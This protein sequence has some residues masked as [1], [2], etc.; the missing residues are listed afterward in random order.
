[1]LVTPGSAV[2]DLAAVADAN[3]IVHLAYTQTTD[4]DSK[5]VYLQ[6]SCAPRLTGTVNTY[7]RLADGVVAGSLATVTGVNLGPG[8]PIAGTADERGVVPAVLA[9]VEVRFDGIAAPVVSASRGQIDVQVPF[10]LFGRSSTRVAA[11]SFGFASDT[12]E[13][14]LAAVRPALRT[15]DGNGSG[16]VVARN[17]DGTS[18]REDNAAE[19][20]SEV[21]LFVTG[22]GDLAPS[23]ATGQTGPQESPPLVPAE[24]SVTIGGSPATLVSAG[25]APGELGIIQVKALVPNEIDTGSVP[26][27]VAIGGVSS[28]GGTTLAVR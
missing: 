12:I 11:T 5:L 20:G 23:L 22:H 19:R 26:V 27:D 8:V 1:V 15:A 18:N 13:I 24:V 9:G 10:E 14:P 4:R 16:A 25:A 17:A 7:S 6:G 2:R 28:Q 3:G 21:T